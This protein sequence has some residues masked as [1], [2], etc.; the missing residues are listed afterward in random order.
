MLRRGEGRGGN[1]AADGGDDCT[2]TGGEGITAKDGD[3]DE[4]DE[5]SDGGHDD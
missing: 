1:D 4:E 2:N 3:D 5:R